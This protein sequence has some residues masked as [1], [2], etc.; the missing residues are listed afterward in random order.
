VFHPNTTLFLILISALEMLQKL[1]SISLKFFAIFMEAPPSMRESSAKRAWLIGS[2]HF[3][4]LMP[5]TV[6]VLFLAVNFLLRVST[7]RMYKKGERGQPCLN[8]LEASK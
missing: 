4:S 8:P 2:I 6:P 1:W 5:G 3:I 7:I